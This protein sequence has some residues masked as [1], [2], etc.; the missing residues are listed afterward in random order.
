MIIMN[1]YYNSG[2]SFQI[3]L[4]GGGRAT[5]A[6]APNISGFFFRAGGA[7]KVLS[8]F[9]KPTPHLFNF[10]SDLM[11]FYS[12]F[13]TLRANFEKI[14]LKK[15]FYTPPPTYSFWG[16]GAVFLLKELLPPSKAPNDVS[17]IIV[18]DVL[19]GKL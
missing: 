13:S 15:F 19:N 18:N 8:V 1:P 14:L 5:S 17:V 2:K 4:W 12:K 3:F 9:R 16:K 10:L 6:P 7:N 11:Y